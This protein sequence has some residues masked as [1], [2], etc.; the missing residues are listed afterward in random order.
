MAGLSFD[1]GQY[2]LVYLPFAL[3]DAAGGAPRIVA[4]VLR[5]LRDGAV[6]AG[7][8]ISAVDALGPL[9]R[10]EYLQP[11]L[12]VTNHAGAPAS[13][14]AVSMEVF[15][16]M[17]RVR[18][19]SVPVPQV[20][21]GQQARIALAAWRPPGEGRYEVTYSL[22]QGDRVL[23]T[24]TQAFDV[25]D[26]EG[27]FTA[28]ELPQGDDGNG[29]ALFD[30]DRDGDLD[31]YV[32]RLRRP[33][34]LY[35]NDRG[36]FVPADPGVGL[37]DSASGRGLA[38]GDWDGDGDPDVFVANYAGG[39]TR[40]SQLY[41]NEV[42]GSAGRFTPAGQALGL[43]GAG[44]HNAAAFGDVDGDGYLDLFVS[45][46]GGRGALWQSRSG[47]GFAA[48]VQGGDPVFRHATIGAAFLDHDNDGDLDLVATSQGADEVGEQLY[49]NCGTAGFVP[50]A[51]LAGL[52]A[53]AVG[54]GV[55][56][57][58]WDGDG[59]QDLLATGPEAT[60]LYHN[61]VRPAHWLAVELRGLPGNSA[62]LG[63]RVEVWAGGQRQVRQVQAA[64][65]YC[66]QGQPRLHFGLGAALRPDS[67]R[68]TWPEGSLTR[69]GP[70]RADRRLVLGHPGRG[71]PLALGE[72]VEETPTG[73]GEAWPNPF[74]GGTL[75]P[76]RLAAAGRVRLE[77]Y[78]VTGQRVR[79]LV[80]GPRPA[81]SQ[82][83]AWNGRDEA[84]RPLGSG[85]YLCRLEVDGQSFTR[86]LLLLK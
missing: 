41:R 57:G 58:D 42:A 70:V 7:P 35:R 17:E 32:V 80:A 64:Y 26:L 10:L 14:Y 11:G 77:V 2:R 53:G 23:D 46:Q 62:A 51:R 45:E 68:L 5:F 3:T 73:L 18:E 86:R 59:R 67:L 65:G 74:N 60:V 1:A 54:R 15:R 85:V 83:A 76:F 13:G 61:E 16:G 27:A 82:Q 24:Q 37:A 20:A 43:E 30:L 33:S 34:T 48:F 50:V 56:V 66:S 22:Q 44:N 39:R 52:R 21:A 81:G 84:G 72:A 38:V 31:A 40:S 29:A 8:V 71:K 4:E 69:L 28:T 79:R 36:R 78:G 55:V 49:Q 6:A 47:Q 9:A 12:V 63:A 19:R 25:V 75:I